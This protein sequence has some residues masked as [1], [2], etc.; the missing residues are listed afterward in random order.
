MIA[1][2]NGH[3]G[4]YLCV[5]LFREHQVGNVCVVDVL[6]ETSIAISTSRDYLSVLLAGVKYSEASSKHVLICDRDAL[7]EVLE[8]IVA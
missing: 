7:R 5:A 6:I 2:G 8:R 1:L 3:C 4:W